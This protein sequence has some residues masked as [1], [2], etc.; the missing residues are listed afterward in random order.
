MG[1][2]APD[3]PVGLRLAADNCDVWA[4]RLLPETIAGW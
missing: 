1:P 2:S 3:W 4:G